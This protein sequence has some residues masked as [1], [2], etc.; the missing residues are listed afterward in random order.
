MSTNSHT[1]SSYSQS[2]R[3]HVACPPASAPTKTDSCTATTS[4]LSAVSRDH[5]K[6]CILLACA[7]VSSVLQ[8]HLAVFINEG[9]SLG[10][11]LDSSLK[12]CLSRRLVKGF[13]LEVLFKGGMCLKANGS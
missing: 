11:R 4:T 10:G 1:K 13:L 7:F 2:G 6:Y 3:S 12:L 5:P 8:C 9:L